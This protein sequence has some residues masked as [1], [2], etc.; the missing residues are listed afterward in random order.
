MIRIPKKVRDRLVK[1]VSRFQKILQ[2]AKDRDVNESDTVTIVTDMLS[3]VFGYDKYSEV[4]SEHA[5]RGTYCDLAIAIDG[6]VKFLVEV[7]AIGLNLKDNHLR[8]AVNYAVNKGI[9]WVILTNGI[10]WEIYSIRFEKPIQADLLCSIDMLAINSKTAED[11]GLLFMICKEGLSRDAMEEYRQRAQIIN[12][13][14]IAAVIQSDPVLN[15]IR[16]EMRRISPD[17]KIETSELEHILV[18]DVLKRDVI[19]GEKAKSAK[20]TVKRHSDRTL[21]KV[22]SKPSDEETSV[23]AE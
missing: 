14:M 13:F 2:D 5:I 19:D 17:L 1:Q 3:W 20:N 10:T 16:R 12:R 6:T 11:Q 18:Q 8:Q 7:K 23:A 4:T 9:Q 21:R 22:G 15:V